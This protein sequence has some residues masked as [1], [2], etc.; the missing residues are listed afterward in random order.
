MKL[1]ICA[2]DIFAGDAVGNH[3]IGIA[4]TAMRFGM[5]AE[6]YAQRFDAT[7]LH[8]QPLSNLF[9]QID[10]DD[11]LLVSYSI[12]DPF[13][14]Q[15]L[16]LPCR[17][18]CYFHGVTDPDLLREFEPRTADLCEASLAQF[19]LLSRFQSFIANSH[20]TA[21]SVAEW[22][23]PT[24]ITI[25]P[26]VFADMPVFLRTPT[27]RAEQRLQPDL[28][29]VGRVVPHK[30]VEDAI[31]VLALLHERKLKFTLSIVGSM[32]NYDYSKFLV[33]QARS[34]SV[35][36]YVN[37]LGM[38]DDEDLLDCY[39]RSSGLLVMSRHEG[40]CV[41]VLEAMHF[42]KPVF[43]RGG[44]AV[45]ELCRPESVFDPHAPL[46]GWADAIASRLADP[47]HVD[48]SAREEITRSQ[49][50]LLR[51]DTSVWQQILLAGSERGDT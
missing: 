33:N 28:M 14:E 16:A 22:I 17:K 40:F 37:F 27:R 44:T 21:R 45:Q 26:P 15:L 31:K 13:L 32:P 1:R 49:E 46:A 10:A 29:V 50:I 41:P 5:Q 35:L 38:V 25:V 12:F 42:G 9:D 4:R 19:P 6:L 18:L 43:I 3:C 51:T 34:L 36:D 30:C 2:P 39:D 24:S 20:S 8:I 47:V 7:V 23:A 11:V 48:A